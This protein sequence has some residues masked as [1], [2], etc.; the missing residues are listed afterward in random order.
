MPNLSRNLIHLRWLLKLVDFRVAGELSW[1][2]AM[3][4]I[5]Y[6]EMCGATKPNKAKSEVAYHYYN[7]GLGFAFYFYVLK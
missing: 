3:L 5:L 1:G 6:R 7:H 2:S 4:A